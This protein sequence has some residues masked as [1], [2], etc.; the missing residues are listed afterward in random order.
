MLYLDDLK[1][2]KLYKKKF[3]IPVDKKDKRHGSAILLL[4]P[5]YESSLLLMNNKFVVN[6][7]R[8]F[9]AYY[10]EKDIMYTIQ[11][12]SHLLECTHE[13]SGLIPINEQA[14]FTE[15]TNVLCM[16]NLDDL[17]INEFY[18]KL[19]DTLIFFNEM[20]DEKIYN[21][22]AGYNTK[23]RKLLYN[24]RMKNNK[25]VFNI[26]DRVKDDNPWIKK[27]FVKYDRYKS[28]NCFIDLYYF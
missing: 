27:T 17:S 23:Y 8:S 13:D 2:M 7:N 6:N 26:Y 28:L 20:Y 22:V 18:C 11:H 16:D 14:T 19:G 15:I 5:N 25:A 21:E 12:E 9:Q 1:Y 24:D 4:T 3:Y 10:I